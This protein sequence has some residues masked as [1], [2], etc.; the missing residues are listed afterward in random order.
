VAGAP[1]FSG[2][3]VMV[4]L[5]SVANAQYVT[6][7]LTNIASSDGG[8]GGSASVRIGFLAGDVNQNRVVTPSDLLSVHAQLAQGVTASNY[9]KDVNASGAVTV[10][11]KG[12]TNANLTRSLPAP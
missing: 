11:D 10:A 8:S 1:T 3:D 2:N 5:S 7:S 9:L 4:A 12:I 6:L